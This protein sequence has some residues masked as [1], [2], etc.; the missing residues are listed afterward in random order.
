[1]TAVEPQGFQ[2]RK[3][4]ES[5]RLGEERCGREERSAW[6]PE[7][8]PR[9]SAITLLRGWTGRDAENGQELDVVA[10]REPGDVLGSP[11]REGLDGHRR[12]AATGRH[13]VRPIADE[14]VR[15]VVRPV[16]PIDHR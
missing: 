7:L 13:E 11:K 6:C 5:R 3:N 10:P 8:C 2:R 9:P 4:K 16:I 15:H 14:E 12:L 1:S